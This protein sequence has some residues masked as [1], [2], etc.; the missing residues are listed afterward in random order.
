MYMYMY[1][2]IYICMYI[3]IYIYMTHPALDDLGL[4]TRRP[5]RSWCRCCS[6]AW[7]TIAWQC[8]MYQQISIIMFVAIPR[9]MADSF[10]GSKRNSDGPQQNQCKKGHNPRRL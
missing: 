10:I 8:I 7:P 5:G 9:Y 1:M 2:Y 6:C 4:P 3:Y